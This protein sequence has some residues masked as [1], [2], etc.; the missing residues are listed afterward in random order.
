MTHGE[1]TSISARPLCAT[2]AL[3]IGTNWALSPEKLLARKVAPMLNPSK[4]GSMG[5]IAL[6]SP[7]FGRDPMSA[8]AEN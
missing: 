5:A 2:A 6:G 3:R 7:F 1:I 8:D 4:T